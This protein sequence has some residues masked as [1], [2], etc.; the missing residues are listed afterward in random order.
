MITGGIES[1]FL[2]NLPVKHLPPDSLY[3]P[4]KDVIEAT[5]FGAAAGG[6]H[7]SADEYAERLV[8]NA[9]KRSP[10]KHQWAGKLATKLWLASTFLWSTAWV[11]SKL[12]GAT[13]IF[14]DTDSCRTI[15]FL[16]HSE[17]RRLKGRWSW[18]KAKV[19]VSLPK[20]VPSLCQYCMVA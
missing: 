4:E 14:A 8:E 13:T 1:Q 3:L 5:M 15:Y 10:Q 7:L 12:L 16:S 20:L 11:G 18:K 9:L 2:N 17:S 6:N 19:K